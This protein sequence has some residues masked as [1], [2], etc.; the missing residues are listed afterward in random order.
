MMDCV[1]IVGGSLGKDFLLAGRCNCQVWL[2]V[3][4]SER[5]KAPPS[6]TYQSDIGRV[7]SGPLER[8]AATRCVSPHGRRAGLSNCVE[9][10]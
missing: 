7:P 3:G 4:A 6:G 5:K 1:K 9:L 2:R 8:Q 10:A